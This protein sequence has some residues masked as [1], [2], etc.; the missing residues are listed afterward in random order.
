[1]SNRLKLQ[2]ELE[3]ILG[4]ENVYY[5]PPEST[6]IVYPAIVYERSDINSKYADDSHY[7]QDDYYRVTFVS[8]NPDSDI[9]ESL[10]KMKSSRYVRHYV[11]DNLYHDTFTIA[12]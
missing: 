2:A 4:S 5:Q 10:S 6:K 1:M 9:V 12:Y 7:I 11:V 8:S 3:R